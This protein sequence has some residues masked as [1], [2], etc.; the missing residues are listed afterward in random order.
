MVCFQ[1]R[2]PVKGDLG[3]FETRDQIEAARQWR[4]KVYVD[5]KR[6]GIWGWVG[7]L[8]FLLH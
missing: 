8:L 3:F 7:L 4:E 6:I 5:G 1:M 2:N